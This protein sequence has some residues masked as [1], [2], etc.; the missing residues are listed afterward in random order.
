MTT[1]D[2]QGVGV[3][4]FFRDHNV[5]VASGIVCPAALE[6]SFVAPLSVFLNGFGGMCSSCVSHCPTGAPQSSQ[7]PWRAVLPPPN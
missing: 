5:T 2:A 4:S 6:A 3:Y 7:P 1:H